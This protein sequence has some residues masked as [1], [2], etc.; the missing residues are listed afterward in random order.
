VYLGIIV[1]WMMLLMSIRV[2]E[3]WTPFSVVAMSVI[4]VVLVTVVI[5]LVRR[6]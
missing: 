4:I 2:A 5:L 1:P 6:S 3:Q